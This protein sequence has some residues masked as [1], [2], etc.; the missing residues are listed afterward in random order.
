MSNDDR[1][2][3]KKQRLDHLSSTSKS[4]KSY[5]NK[6]LFQSVLPDDSLTQAVKD[7]DIVQ[8]RNI[9]GSLSDI[10]AVDSTGVTALQVAINEKYLPGIKLLLACRARRLNKYH[11]IYSWN[12][13]QATLRYRIFQRW[14]L[15]SDLDWVNRQLLIGMRRIL[16]T[17]SVPNA[18]EL[19]LED[20]KN[21]SIKQLNNSSCSDRD[22]AII[23]NKYAAFNQ[24]DDEN[25]TMLYFAIKNDNTAIVKYLLEMDVDVTVTAAYKHCNYYG[26]LTALDVAV[27]LEQ[28]NIVQLLLDHGN[29]HVNFKAESGL[30]PL[31]IAA[32]KNNLTIA[33]K[34]ISKGATIDVYSTYQS[35][36]Y[37][38]TNRRAVHGNFI[39]NHYQMHSTESKIDTD[40]EH[41]N[42]MTALQ[43]AAKFKSL[44][45]V[46]L[47]VDLGGDVNA[48]CKDRG[49]GYTALHY[50]VMNYDSAMV[51]FL[52]SK[53][54][55]VNIKSNDE[56]TILH[57]A[58]G[59]RNK[60][61]VKRLLDAG[62]DVNIRSNT[63]YF[64][65]ITPLLEAV[66][67]HLKETVLML[68]EMGSDINATA[69]RKSTSTCVN[70]IDM[71]LEELDLDMLELML[72]MGADVSGA[73]FR[74]YSFRNRKIFRKH[75]EKFWNAGLFVNKRLIKWADLKITKKY[76]LRNKRQAQ[77]RK[78]EEEEIGDRYV[79]FYD[80]LFKNLDQMVMY[81]ENESI[82]KALELNVHSLPWNHQV[83][84]NSF[85]EEYKRYQLQKETEKMLVN[86]IDLPYL[87]VRKILMYFSYDD[88]FVY[89]GRP[90]RFKLTRHIDPV[91][92]YRVQRLA[93]R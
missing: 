48:H 26:G 28:E 60:D 31:H 82:W 57:F 38:T 91:G 73:E 6:R 39:R 2:P 83:L 86:I 50:A 3:A 92:R 51:D 25:Q 13:W 37:S 88:L 80:L 76:D 17:W 71:T 7:K 85:Q 63:D 54:A 79:S 42:G 47:L 78:M 16:R 5:L 46:Q 19:T 23:L 58:V 8:I 18:E 64:D 24:R 12:L 68:I 52:L 89:L 43:V 20:L 59:T 4:H 36:P 87:C 61:I 11:S 29:C 21:Y 49:D 14:A 22:M 74:L 81:A 15:K 35:I 45:M 32:L 41:L 65:D 55:R 93:N 62:A 34:L 75:L 90:S 40:M 77:V 53:G 84:I 69:K 70:V 27:E 10:D 33:K 1:R 9:V 56:K 44:E 30:T 72:N 66:R 67:F